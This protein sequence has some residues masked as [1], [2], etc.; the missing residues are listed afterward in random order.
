MVF[1]LS[2]L[3]LNILVGVEMLIH[4]VQYPDS[5][6]PFGTL[7]VPGVDGEVLL[8]FM[9]KNRSN[10][11]EKINTLIREVKHASNSSRFKKA[12]VTI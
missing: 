12:L 2:M 4:M 11:L 5:K 9:K 3:K 10:Y 8:S 1:V 6:S 7:W